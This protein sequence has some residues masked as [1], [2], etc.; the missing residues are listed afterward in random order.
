MRSK[1][2]GT[3]LPLAVVPGLR[4]VI[5]T[6]QLFAQDDEATTGLYQAARQQSPV[7]MMFQLGEV[8]GQLM[9]IYLKSV[10]PSVPAFDDSDMRLTWKFSDTR[11]QGTAEDEVVVAFG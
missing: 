2:Y 11:A 6:L 7:S 3:T 9:G 1:E 5:V 10:V 4:S 8:P